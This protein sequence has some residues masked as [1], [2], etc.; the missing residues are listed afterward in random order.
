MRTGKIVVL[1]ILLAFAL[2]LNACN[3]K[4]TEEEPEFVFAED[5]VF[6]VNGREVSVG[7]WNLYIRPLL[8]ETE[9]IYGTDIWK[10]TMDAEGKKFGEAMQEYVRDT[11]VNIKVV[12]GYASELGL[13]LSDEEKIE[14]RAKA[15]EYMKELS[16]SD[17]TKYGITQELVES[18]YSDNYLANE[19]YEYITLNVDTETD[20]TEVRHMSLRYI[21][22]P[23]TYE[24]REGN[25][26]FLSDEEI[27]RKRNE[28]EAIRTRV[29]DN[30]DISLK[31]YESDS[32]VVT[33]IITD[34][35]GLKERLPEDMAGIVFW[36]RQD[37]ISRVLESD[38]ALF[39]FE[40][41]DVS[42]EYT[43][44]AARIK[45]IEQREQQVFEEA[46]SKWKEDVEVVYNLSEWNTITEEMKAYGS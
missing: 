38:E 33:D 37:E 21:M 28:L 42:D 9:N 40:C 25:T 18:V 23:K 4:K 39:L 12:S 2:V 22:Q 16:E 46:Y 10:Y 30:K 3:S 43:T 19:V 26:L 45:V 11:I 6:A 31:D 15:E 27:E 7:E 5:V 35:A 1:G 8:D 41:V 34:Y 20:E 44:N 14:I 32:I 29:A 36:L 17:R 24:D 13:S